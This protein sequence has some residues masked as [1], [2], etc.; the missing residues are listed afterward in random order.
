MQL[1]SL[2]RRVV[3]EGYRHK[4][5]LYIVDWGAGPVLIKDFRKKSW[6]RRALGRLQ[7]GREYRAYTWLGR[8]EG[9]PRV[10]GRIDA[11]ALAIEWVE[12]EL[13]ATAPDRVSDGQRYVRELQH[14]MCRLHA[15]G[16]AHLDLRSNKN[17]VIRRGGQLV[18][19]DFASALWCRPGGLIHR[20]CFPLLQAWDLSGWL[21]WKETLAAGP[22]TDDEHA[23]L[24]RH[25]K[26]SSLWVFNR[27]RR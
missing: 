14:V 10:F 24:R 27:K 23:Q 7:T 13:L 15:T 3:R 11:H 26:L 16:L 5:D 2:E 22:L 9:I 17:V 6:L 4:A 12:G 20:L 19:V 25:R 1:H 18:V 8:M 21:K